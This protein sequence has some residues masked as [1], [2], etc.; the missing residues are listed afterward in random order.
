MTEEDEEFNRIEREASLR[1]AAVHATVTKKPWV[2]L[3]DKERSGI[4]REA[5]GWG[6]PSHDDIGLMI[7]IEAL[8]KEKNEM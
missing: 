6:D 1:K 3:T 7:A 4:W 2:G 8:L 5:I